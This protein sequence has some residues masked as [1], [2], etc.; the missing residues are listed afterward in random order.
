M[1]DFAWISVWTRACCCHYDGEKD[2]NG[3]VS[4]RDDLRAVVDWLWAW[5]SICVP[6]ASVDIY[7]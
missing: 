4:I 2:G 6:F 5:T 3:K 7:T 1:E